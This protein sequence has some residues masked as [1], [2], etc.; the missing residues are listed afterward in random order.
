M[1]QEP[2][3]NLRADLTHFSW[4]ALVALG[5]A[6]QEGKALTKKGQ[7]QF[8]MTW[9]ANAQKYKLFPRSLA[10]E[11]LSLQSEGKRQGEK[12]NLVSQ[13]LYLWKS[14]TGLLAEENDLFR[15][16]YFIDLISEMGWK[17]VLLSEDEWNDADFKFAPQPTMY[18]K[19]MDIIT[20][21]DD[22]QVR[23]HP[24]DLR[25]TGDIEAIMSSFDAS[26][27]KVSAATAHDNFAQI[28]LVS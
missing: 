20:A 27:L 4:C 12:A 3:K 11:I 10:S 26:F 21:F 13:L 7:H 14:S 16:T 6:R 15:L 1:F 2:V 8:M 22:D 24:V 19:K 17:H 25:F 23:T 28:T 9:L 18:M 5:L